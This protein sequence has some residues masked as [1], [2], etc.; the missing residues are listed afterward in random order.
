MSLLITRFGQPLGPSLIW[1]EPVESSETG[2]E[3]PLAFDYLGQRVGNALFPRFTTRTNRAWYF[4][5]VLY[6]LHLAGRAVDVYGLPGDDRRR[7]SL[8][9]RWERVWAM[10]TLSYREGELTRGDDDAMRGIEGAKRHWQR[11]GQR[12]AIPLDFQL[13]SRQS[14]LGA[15]GAY[16]TSLRALGLVGPGSYIPT[17]AAWTIIASFWGEG[18]GREYED[19]V[20]A[21][22]DP[23]T[24]AIPQRSGRLSLGNLGRRSRLTCL[25]DEDRKPQREQLWRDLFQGPARRA[26]GRVDTTAEALAGLMR[27]AQK[28]GWDGDPE[29]WLAGLEAGQWSGTDAHQRSVA[30]GAVAFGRLAR[31]LLGLFDAIFASVEQAGFQV[32]RGRVVGEVVAPALDDLRQLAEPFLASPAVGW[33]QALEVHGRPLVALAQSLGTGS[34]D[35]T[36]SAVLAYHRQVQVERDRAEGWIADGEV[37]ALRFAGYTGH[38]SPAVFPNLKVGP[39]RRL[40]LDLKRI[41]P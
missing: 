39:V 33:F 12:D 30:S 31:A 18:A 16:L 27:Q 19:F 36:L 3:D 1:A 40:L 22:L 34:P 11:Y 37:L 23:D 10:A 25:D 28:L 5:V 32:E 38:R 24:D 29:R 26:D 14:E 21:A 7:I 2:I 15:L 8:F 9:E 35:Q 13:I 6:G 4:A 20:L 41:R 17:T